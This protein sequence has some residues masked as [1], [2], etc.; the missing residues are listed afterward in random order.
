MQ[1]GAR[2][3]KAPPK[4]L[5]TPASTKSPC[6]GCQIRGD[7]VRERGQSGRLPVGACAAKRNDLLTT[8]VNRSRKEAPVGVG[9]TMADL[10][11][12]ALATWLRR[13]VFGFAAFLTAQ[14]PWT[15]VSVS[16]HPIRY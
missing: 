10:Q 12:A 4:E 16:T 15:M 14:K 9:P 5:P 13:L 3:S 1:G 6:D 7:S 8:V 11:S 2:Y